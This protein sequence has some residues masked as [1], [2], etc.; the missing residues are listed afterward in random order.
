M[1]Y[2]FLLGGLVILGALVRLF[3]KDK[4]KAI[5]SDKISKSEIANSFE[6]KNQRNNRLLRSRFRKCRF[7]LCKDM[8]KIFTIEDTQISTITSLT[9]F[10]H[11]L[12]ANMHQ[13]FK[14]MYFGEMSDKLIT[15]SQYTTIFIWFL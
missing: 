1:S 8:K 9:G 2:S 7:R 10:S 3:I 5:V 14:K 13:L 4:T 15:V 6:I 12:L 11:W